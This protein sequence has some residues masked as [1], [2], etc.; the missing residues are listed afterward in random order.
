[1]L[2]RKEMDIAD[3]ASV[4]AA[5]DRH[6]PWAVINAAGYA[7]IDD[8]ENDHAR[9][10]RENTRGAA[11]LATACAEG[12]VRFVTFSADLVFGGGQSR[13]YVE[14]DDVQPLG[15]YATSKALAEREVM[16][17]WPSSLIVRTGAFFGPWDD[18]NFVITAL[19]TLAN[20]RLVRAAADS[21]VSPTYLPDLVNATLDLLI[22]GTS[23][24]WHLANLG[25]VTWA[26]LARRSASMAGVDASGVVPCPLR[27][28][29]FLAPRP[30]YC[31]LG[32]QR[33]QLL[34]ALEESLA[35]FVEEH[36][37]ARVR[38]RAA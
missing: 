5:L 3:P 10:D 4:R 20:G 19:R 27:S 38:E 29:G 6:S 24:I 18:H 32:S 9:C 17:V 30:S 7:R 2:S 16:R 23:G 8:A 37:R 21:V 12:H 28:L 34:P 33:G 25:A 11:A 14:S 22:D 35:R 36:R 26:D 31:T 13:P 1:V 15:V